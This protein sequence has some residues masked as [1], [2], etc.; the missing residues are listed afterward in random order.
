MSRII[1][2]LIPDKYKNDYQLYRQ[3]ITEAWIRSGGKTKKGI[4]LDWKTKQLFGKFNVMAGLV[5]DVLKCNDALICCC[6]GFPNYSAWP[7]TYTHELIPIIWD[8]WPQYHKRMLAS[9]RQ[10]KIKTVFCT[11]SQTR[12]I[13]K[14][15]YP[16]INVFWLPE[17]IDTEVYK[18]GGLLKE[19]SIDVLELGRQLPELHQSLI[20]SNNSNNINHQFSKPG[21]LLFKDF[22]DL[23][24]GLSDSKITICYPRCDTHPDMAGNIETLTQRYWECMLSGT[25]IV[26]RAPKELIEFC[27]YNPIV[28]LKENTAQEISDILSHIEDFQPLVD[29]NLEFARENASWDSRMP[30]LRKHLLE[31]GYIL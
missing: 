20:E 12:D 22:N 10:C 17:G 14:S 28:D 30:Y 3:W 26:G 16:D 19:R 29:K 24:N 2:W 9:L 15:T 6:G 18:S 5:P 31:L 27:G 1:K 13:I 25:L 11:S 8:C 4:R 21:E 23:V 7:Y